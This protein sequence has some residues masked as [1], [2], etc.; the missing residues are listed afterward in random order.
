[1]ADGRENAY[2]VMSHAEGPTILYTHV[3]TFPVEILDE[4]PMYDLFFRTLGQCG[5]ERR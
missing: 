5:R 2:R 3:T 4:E 1:M